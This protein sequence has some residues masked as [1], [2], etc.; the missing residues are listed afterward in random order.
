M[1][2]LNTKSTVGPRL[3][4]VGST[5][6]GQSVCRRRRVPLMSGRSARSTQVAVSQAAPTDRPRPSPDTV[7]RRPASGSFVRRGHGAHR[8][9]PHWTGQGRQPR[10]RWGAGV[11]QQERQRGRREPPSFPLLLLHLGP[12]QRRGRPVGGTCLPQLQR[13][14]GW[15]PYH[16][17]QLQG[18]SDRRCY[19]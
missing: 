9:R 3:R 19:L 14:L 7:A 4:Q 8:T 11:G 15:E 16:H 1:I 13:P 6:C 17:H 12:S 10:R 18:P 5:G 2:H